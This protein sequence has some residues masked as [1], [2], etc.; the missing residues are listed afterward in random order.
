MSD[1]QLPEENLSHRWE[2]RSEVHVKGTIT[3][4]TLNFFQYQDL[5]KW[6]LV[7]HMHA[8]TNKMWIYSHINLDCFK[9]SPNEEFILFLM[10]NLNPFIVKVKGLRVRK[11]NFSPTCIHQQVVS[12]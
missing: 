10:F 11:G 5:P 7:I 9:K 8:Y 6:D 4:S 1:K 2:S 3:D 12:F